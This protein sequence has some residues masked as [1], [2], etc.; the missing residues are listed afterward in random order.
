MAAQ[1]ATQ[2]AAVADAP[3]GE[4]HEDE[5]VTPPVELTVDCPEFRCAVEDAVGQYDSCA[6]YFSKVAHALRHYCARGRKLAES[7]RQLSSQMKVATQPAWLAKMEEAGRS[8]VGALIKGAKD[9]DLSEKLGRIGPVMA[10]F[11]NML[12]C[13]IASQEVLYQSLESV[14]A[15]KLEAFASEEHA[16]LTA[17]HKRFESHLEAHE[18]AVARYLHGNVRAGRHNHNIEPTVRARAREVT[19]SREAYELSR[20][21][22]VDKLAELKAKQNFELSEAAAACYYT[23]RTHHRQSTENLNEWGS[24][25]DDMHERSVKQR[26]QHV[27]N[28]SKRM[29]TLEGMREVLNV[30]AAR[31][32]K[33]EEASGSS[34]DQHHESVHWF[35]F[36]K[37]GGAAASAEEGAEGPSAQHQSMARQSDGRAEIVAKVSAE[38]EEVFKPFSTASALA[39]LLAPLSTEGR[40]MKEGWLFKRS[41]SAMMSNHWNRRWFQLD[42]SCLYYVRARSGAKDAEEDPAS[43][44]LPSASD[45]RMER[46]LVCDCLLATVREVRVPDL[47]HCFEILSANRRSYMLQAEGPEEQ[48]AWMNAIRDCIAQQLATGVPERPRG[49]ADAHS[50]GERSQGGLER[51][52]SGTVMS[53][54]EEEA[55]GRQVEELQRR[56]PRCADCGRASPEWAIINLGCLVCIECSGIHRSLGVHISKVRSLVLDQLEPVNMSILLR[57][58]NDQVN[59]ILEADMA[60]QTGWERPAPDS[61]REEKEKFIRSKYLYK[62]FMAASP[63]AAPGSAPPGGAPGRAGAASGPPP[64]P[65]KAKRAAPAL[66]PKP[67]G[68]FPAKP[69][70]SRRTLAEAAAL[71]KERRASEM[72]FDAATRDDIRDMLDAYAH[73][74]GVRWK[75][76]TQ[77]N[78]T[79]LCAAAACGNL[80]CV[81]FLL[82]NGADP[83]ALDGDSCNA[84][85]V[86]AVAGH[87]GVVEFLAAKMDA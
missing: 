33:D 19:L 48:R 10:E 75:N 34:G 45:S 25:V 77:R 16:G 38:A 51:T 44:S 21:E 18:N 23:L 79:A 84:M 54:A 73:G 4:A 85:D 71:Q 43:G 78:R 8:R 40:L 82:L 22:L 42:G 57:L 66:P 12:D 7:S 55:Y 35:D 28:A 86:A 53:N 39:P 59:A 17:L 47:R 69:G 81:E 64:L 61:S 29:R 87:N 13:M 26:E 58:G 15:E 2:I 6:H 1:G 60:S 36:R 56:S 14:F 74:G 76:R 62:G 24:F 11:G 32:A 80:D 3:S 20:F 37:G 41:S 68:G 70:R 46:V 5:R 52:M 72:L 49:E 31:E 65:A 50:P 67:E 30:P 63:A 9:V 83:E 27:E